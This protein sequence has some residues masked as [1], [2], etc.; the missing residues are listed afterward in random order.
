MKMKHLKTFFGMLILLAAVSC[1]KAQQAGEGHVSFGVFSDDNVV[2]VTRSAVSSYTTLPQKGDF[3]ID[4]KNA[5]SQTVWK[6]NVGDWDPATPLPAGNYSVTAWY[7]DIEE[8]GFDKPYFTGSASFAIA[9]GETKSVSVPV[10]LGNTVV[11]VSCTEAFCNYYRNY[12]FKLTRN[13]AEI[14]TFAKGETK[15]AFIDGYKVSIEGSVKSATNT[16]AFSKDYTNL[17]EATAYTVVF[18]VKNVGGAS[19]TVT[20]NNEVVEVPLGDVELND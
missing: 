8:E 4:I 1:N 9:G 15:A 11:M 16:K 2:D 5:S 19:I 3:S 6:G 20:F 18:D 7:G 13:N 12:T 17:N 10:S 14:V